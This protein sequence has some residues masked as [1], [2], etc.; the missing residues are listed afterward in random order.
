MLW[1]FVKTSLISISIIFAICAIGAIFISLFP[2]VAAFVVGVAAI[3]TLVYLVRS[4]YQEHKYYVQHV[5]PTE[6]AFRKVML[7]YWKA[8]LKSSWADFKKAWAEYRAQK[9]TLR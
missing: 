4:A 5:K 9:T 1:S 3:W 7:D 8:C 6:D 2:F